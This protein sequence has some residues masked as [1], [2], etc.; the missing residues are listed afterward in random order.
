MV[1][2]SVFTSLPAGM[3]AV[4]AKQFGPARQKQAVLVYDTCAQVHHRF[5]WGLCSPPQLVST[6]FQDGQCKRYRFSLGTAP[7]FFL[8]CKPCCWKVLW[9]TILWFSSIDCS[10]WDQIC[11]HLFELIPS[12]QRKT[13]LTGTFREPGLLGESRNKQIAQS[14]LNS[15]LPPHLLEQ[16]SEVSGWNSHLGDSRNPDCPSHPQDFWLPGLGWGHG[17]RLDNKSWVMLLLVWGH[18]LRSPSLGGTEGPLS[19]AFL[20]NQGPFNSQSTP[21][22]SFSTN[23]GAMCILLHVKSRT[24]RDGYWEDF[25]CELFPVEQMVSMLWFTPPAQRGTTVQTPNLLKWRLGPSLQPEEM[26]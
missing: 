7:T 12:H 10:I 9:V 3:T 24:Q 20:E 19:V 23:R 1:H 8:K 2:S 17:T 4:S 5:N 15:V 11:N 14:K 21:R 18:I 6:L 16:V 13:W 25:Q 22:T 26:P